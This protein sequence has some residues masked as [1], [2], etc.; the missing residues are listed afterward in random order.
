MTGTEEVRLYANVAYDPR[1]WLEIPTYF[2]PETWASPQEWAA[3]VAPEFWDGRVPDRQGIP[4]LE[5][6]FTHYARECGGTDPDLPFEV[7]AYLHVPDPSQ[8]PMLVQVWIDTT[9]G[10]TVEQAVQ[11]KD[12]TTVEPPLVTPFSSEHL[13]AGLRALLY[14]TFVPDPGIESDGLTASVRYAFSIP[15]QEAV[16]TVVTVEP[17][18]GRLMQSMDDLD[19][20]VRQVRWGFEPECLARVP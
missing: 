8:F 17:D 11:A 7:V 4:R 5:A 3:E 1:I 19:E 10:L 16:L 15:E 20:F 13:G 14:C 12:P 2:G 9:P 6:I 18:L